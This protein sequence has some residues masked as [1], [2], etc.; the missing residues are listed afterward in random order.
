[1]EDNVGYQEQDG[2][3]FEQGGKGEQDGRWD[4]FPARINYIAEKNPR[5]L[6]E[7]GLD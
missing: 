2:A 5:L 3:D 6:R 4:G 7:L 1:M